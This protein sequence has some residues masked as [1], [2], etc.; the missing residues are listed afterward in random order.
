MKSYLK[1][2]ISMLIFGSLIVFI[3]SISFA[4]TQIVLARTMLGSL[5]LFLFMLI[6]KH[7]F[8][9]ANIKKNI[10]PLLVAGVALGLNWLFLFEA[11][12]HI[13]VSVA[14]M[15]Y[16]LS[17]VIMVVVSPFLLKEKLKIRTVVL[18]C[19][20][21][22]GMFLVNG[23]TTG[24]TSLVGTV[25]G[26]LSACLYVT[27]VI[28]NK[29]IKDLKSVEISFIEMLISCVIM[30][31]YTLAT[32]GIIPQVIDAKSVVNLLIVGLVHTAIAYLLY[33][34]SIQDLPAQFVAVFS[35]ID[36][37][38]TLILSAL[39]LHE[40]MTFV[41]IIGAVLIMGSAAFEQIFTKKAQ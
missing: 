29:F 14:T 41:Q 11:Y 13:P 23:F 37:V 17:P 38:F 3:K 15:L 35:Y 9:W 30:F 22:F 16:Y 1:L 26:L 4:S 40:D 8:V 36:P 33:F 18:V 12:N 6:G 32:D 19:V 34:S 27:V 39:V 21:L 2:I 20:A 24:Q 31:F 5:F 7:K 10:V 28:S 25:L